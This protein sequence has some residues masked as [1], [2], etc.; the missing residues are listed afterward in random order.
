MLIAAHGRGTHLS[1]K[2]DAPLPRY[3]QTMGRV[4]AMPIMGR[5]HREG[6]SKSIA[7][8]DFAVRNLLKNSR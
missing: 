7:V 4:L 2:K 6:F 8:A 1:L 5:S 3:T